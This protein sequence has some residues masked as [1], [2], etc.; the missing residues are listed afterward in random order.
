MTG[1]GFS[2]G[3]LPASAA[4]RRDN[5]A[6]RRALRGLAV[7]ALA[8]TFTLQSVVA[9]AQRRSASV[10]RDAEIEALVRD[11]AVP[12][13]R[14]ARIN[15]R[16][17]AIYVIDDRSFNAFVADGRRLFI[18]AGT[19]M[20]AK[21]PNEIIGVIAHEAG[22]IAGGHLA[23]LRQQLERA[24]SASIIT[25]LLG[26]GALAASAASGSGSAGQ[27]G[28][29]VISGGQNVILR[30]L[31]AYQR[32]EES[33]A[34][35]AALNYLEATG[36]SAKGMITT[37][38][39]FADQQLVSSRFIDP[40]VQTHPLPRE[41]ISQ[42]TTLA[43][44]SPFFDRRDPPALQLRHDMMRAKLS[45]FMEHFDTV[46][47][48]YPRSDTSLPARYARAIALYRSADLRRAVAEID[49][50]I[51]EQ[52]SNPYFWELKGQ[53]LLE[54]S[55]PREAIEPLRQAVALAPQADL[56][57]LLYGQALLATEDNRNLDAAI[58]QLSKGLQG[59][60]DAS[61]GFRQLA[62]AYGRKGDIPRADLATARAYF[63]EGDLAAAKQYANRVQQKAPRGSPL[64]LQA[65]DILNFRPPKS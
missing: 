40:Y 51:R 20:D 49:G 48:R 35:R 25:M 42:M 31:L 21:T 7:T 47:R 32:A 19:L 38:R 57:R 39:R 43:P 54:G 55:R 65:D 58:Q 27:A 13:F 33:A 41:R 50:L 61:V 6:Y 15:S 63:V 3:W 5:S 4:K 12:I 14:A 29:A 52:P 8:A 36:Q 45:G 62:I 56:I 26:L 22:H 37:F 24:Q 59:E 30:N 17:V 60:P 9:E 11:Y 18:N 34:D 1:F 64:W 44:Q 10:I 16:A 23:R 28:Q 53:A 2:R 46:L